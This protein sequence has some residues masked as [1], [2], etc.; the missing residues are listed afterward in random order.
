MFHGDLL[1]YLHFRFPTFFTD[2]SRHTQPES[3]LMFTKWT[4]YLSFLVYVSVCAKSS[5]MAKVL[6]GVQCDSTMNKSS[7]KQKYNSH[8]HLLLWTIS[9]LYSGFVIPLFDDTCT[10][11]KKINPQKNWRH[12]V[13]FQYSYAIHFS[14]ITLLNSSLL[15]IK[16]ND[17]I[18]QFD[19]AWKSSKK[20]NSAHV[21]NL[22]S[23]FER[24]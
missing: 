20:T 6:L 22:N 8:I 5:C 9:L 11:R 4:S 13:I 14:I 19:M 24:S 18:Y 16:N 10:E 17:I 7:S 1:R 21:L 12:M 15:Y 3:Y 23:S 2:N